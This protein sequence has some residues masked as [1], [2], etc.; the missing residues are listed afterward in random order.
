MSFEWY[1]HLCEYY[2]VTPEE[3][4]E[5]GTRRFGRKPNLPASV[6]THKVSGMTLE[7]IWELSERKAT[8]DVFQFYKDQ[9]S[10]STFRQ[11]VRHKD[12]EHLHLSTFK[13]LIE[14]EVI[15]DG[16]HLCEYGAGVA[17]FVTTF[18][19]YLNPDN[20]P[21]LTITII[22][23]DCEHFNFAKYRLN[24]IKEDKGYKNID[25]NFEIVEVDTLPT[26]NNQK[27]DALLCFEVLEHVP[28]PIAVINN[29]KDAM[30]PGG[31]CIE[32]FIKHNDEDEDEDGPD[33][34]TARK[35]RSDYYEIIGENFNL[36]YPSLQES[37]RNPNCT[38]FWQKKF[39]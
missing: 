26:F 20:D 27:L 5:L 17:P 33:L 30:R 15:S 22:D 12:M 1:T 24:K 7:D 34:L 18:L 23:V 10:W 6:T 13:R 19:K 36:I 16:A 2:S 21:K 39:L 29:I 14:N 3:A 4:L 11:C 8:E 35:E 31:I 32:N 9:G 38:R 37:E 25:F 28:S